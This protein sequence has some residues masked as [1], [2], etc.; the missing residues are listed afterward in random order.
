MNTMLPL[1]HLGRRDARGL[2]SGVRAGAAL[3]LL[4][5]AC[6]ACTPSRSA[7]A[8]RDGAPADTLEVVVADAVTARSTT[9][10]D[11]RTA[12]VYV[13]YTRTDEGETNVYLARLAAGADTLAPAVR[14]NDVA[15]D[16]AAHAQAPAQVAVAPDGTVY[17]TWITQTPI[18]GRR[19]PASDLRLARSDDG[20]RTFSP[21]VTVNPDAGFPTSHHFHNLAVGPQ[22]T[23]F[24]SWLDGSAKDRAARAQADAVSG[25]EMTDGTHGARGHH[26]GGHSVSEDALPGTALHVARSVDRG[27]TFAPGVVV[28]EGTCQCCRT[29][30]AV[31]GDGTLYVAWRHIF[32]E[33][34]RDMAI[35]RSEDDGATFSTPARVHADE[36]QINGCPHSGPAVAVDAQ[37]RVT[38][39][40]YTGAET[41]AGVYRATSTDGGLTFDAPAQLTGPVPIAQVAATQADA[42]EGA[43]IAWE[44]PLRDSLYV[45]AV[46]GATEGA[47][48]RLRGDQPDVASLGGTDAFVWRDGEQIRLRVLR[49]AD[50]HPVAAIVR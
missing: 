24:V 5:T 41:A 50:V 21:A 9:A 4:L 25:T 30:L 13:A 22:G 40:W 34:I 45:Q 31:A 2:A 32:G 7:D 11:P 47:L 20:G 27:R 19:F 14:V 38:V 46:R 39:A 10:I 49:R 36:W 43:L 17:V 42:H 33:H 3:I 29:A 23:V 15:G 48:Q 28:A 37:D 16:A 18:T 6:A 26:G 12:D 1:S 8:E 35:A 44:H